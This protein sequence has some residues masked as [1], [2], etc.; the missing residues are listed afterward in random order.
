MTDEMWD[1]VLNNGPWPENA[2]MP[3]EKADAMR[4]EF[5]YFY[6]F[7]VRSSGTPMQR[8]AIALL[9]YGNLR[10]TKE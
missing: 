7:D 2:P 8:L 3:K 4:H 1:Y 6:P 10:I 5:E 9:T